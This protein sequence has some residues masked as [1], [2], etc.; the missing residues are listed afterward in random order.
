MVIIPAFSLY[1]A[2]VW[3]SI[4]FITNSVKFPKYHQKIGLYNRNYLCFLWGRNFGVICYL[5]KFNLQGDDGL[6][7][8]V[9]VELS[10]KNLPLEA[11]VDCDQV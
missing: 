9:R 11:Y 8:I 6:I 10:G 4:I 2:F 1:S 7:L 3:V 5:Y